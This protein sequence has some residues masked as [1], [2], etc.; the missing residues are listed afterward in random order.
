MSNNVSFSFN[1][2]QIQLPYMY[3]FISFYFLSNISIHRNMYIAYI[4]LRL[5]PILFRWYTDS[6][7]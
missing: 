3:I 6:T 4:R 1:N 2:L 7:N 5:A